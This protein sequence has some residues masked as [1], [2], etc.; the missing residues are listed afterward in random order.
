MALA[1]PPR[2]SKERTREFRNWRGMNVTDSRTAIDDDELAWMENALTIGKGAI[3]IL[4]GPA[5]SVATIAGGV[6]EL[7]GCILNGTSVLIAVSGNGSVH[8]V[9]PGGVVTQLAGPGTL[10][11]GHGPH[12][13][14]WRG[15]RVLIIDPNNGYFSW[16]GNAWTVISNTRTGSHIAVFEGRVWIGTNRTIQFTAPNTYDNFAAGDGAGSTIITD[17]AFDGNITALVSALEQLWVLGQSAIEAIANVTSTGS[18]PTVTTTFSVT[19]IVGGI[20]TNAPHTVEAYF[21]ALVF[22]APFG[23]YA[24]SGVTPQKLSDK[25]DRLFP[26]LTMDDRI[27]AAIAV[28][29]SL[30][31]LL[32]LVTYTGPNAQ[33]GAAPTPL[34]LGF[35]QGKWFLG[36]QGTTLRW[37]TTLVV[38]GVSQAWGANTASEIFRLFAASP[39]TA[40]TYKVQTKLYH[41]GTS[42]TM[43][44]LMALGLELQAP[45]LPITPTITIESE[46]ATAS[47]TLAP[48]DTLALTGLGG[49]VL[50]LTGAGAQT[51]TLATR[52]QNIVRQDAM[53]AGRYLGVTIA[54]TDPPYL[55][56]AIQ[57]LTVPDEEWAATPP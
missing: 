39:T 17:E 28:I 5:A 32:F 10:S 46:A 31:C 27:S 18:P 29:E 16:D 38:D 1:R 53:L 24:L 3:Q 44:Q 36:A 21:R 40:V 12:M 33:A 47:I 54:G 43:Q 45:N 6:A 57:M 56:Q 23:V 48:A 8:Q 37:I 41:A 35:T 14:V 9:T 4:L 42:T 30:P 25:L 19:N 51:L 49:A 26:Q 50:T 55:I 15:A 22:L 13:T 2:P 11:G 52:G 7:F 20:G 34:L